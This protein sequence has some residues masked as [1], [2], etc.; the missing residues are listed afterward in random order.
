MLKLEIGHEVVIEQGRQVH[1]GFE[2]EYVLGLE[3]SLTSLSKWEQIWE[4]PFLD[5]EKMTPE[6]MISYIECMVVSDDPPENWI[7][8]L[9]QSNIEAVNQYINAKMSATWF[10]DDPYYVAKK[11]TEKITWELIEYW[12]SNLSSVPPDYKHWHLNNLFNF[13]KIYDV[14]NRKPT[15]RSSAESAAD[16]RIEMARRRALHNSRG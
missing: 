5:D 7:T 6:Q 16:R 11:G 13:I 10:N 15:Q 12:L 3:H 2:V 14:K 9:T 1:F 4:V 8:K